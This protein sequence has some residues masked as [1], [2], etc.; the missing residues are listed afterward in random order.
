MACIANYDPLSLSEIATAAET[1]GTAV[2]MDRLS[3]S[4]VNLRYAIPSPNRMFTC[5]LFSSFT[6]RKMCRYLSKSGHVLGSCVI[7]LL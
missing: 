2:R 4:F 1:G 7:V 6:S 5:S 3:A